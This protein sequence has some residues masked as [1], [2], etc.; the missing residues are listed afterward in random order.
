MILEFF[1]GSTWRSL[2]PAGLS[3]VRH[4]NGKGKDEAGMEEAL[5]HLEQR[6]TALEKALKKKK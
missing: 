6:V 5:K 3:S 1:D 4:K 2:I